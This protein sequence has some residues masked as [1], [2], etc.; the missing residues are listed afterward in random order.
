[1]SWLVESEGLV[2]N[3]SQWHEWRRHHIGASDVPA[4]MGTG[5]WGGAFEVYQAKTTGE[6]FEG[7]FATERGKALEPIILALFEQRHG[8]RLTSPTIES[9]RS[10]FLSASLDGWNEKEKYIVEIKAPAFWKH[11]QSLC[12]LVPECYE[13]QV[14]TQLYVAESDLAY[15]VSY[16]D[17]APEGFQYA[18]VI[19]RPDKARQDLILETTK[20]F[21]EMVQSG[22]WNE[23]W[24]K[25]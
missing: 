21:W 13:D 22:E 6:R 25:A 20:R 16:S 17:Y 9:K 2:Q 1:M 23:N 15:Y 7:N 4:I 24:N 19:V 3:S 5:S 10:L 14:Q 11:T 18:E 8:S 12:G